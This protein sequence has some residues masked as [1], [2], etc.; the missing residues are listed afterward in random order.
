MPSANS[1]HADERLA[2]K[3]SSQHLQVPV[4]ACFDFDSRSSTMNP[5]EGDIFLNIL[6]GIIYMVKRIV[7]KMVILESIDGERHI[8]TG[9][10]GLKL[11]HRKKELSKT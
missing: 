1:E 11:F 2:D 4:K 8:L 3:R 9:F 7:H 6:D 5:K 10:E